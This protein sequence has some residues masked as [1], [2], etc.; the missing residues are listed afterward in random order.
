MSFAKGMSNREWLI[1]QRAKSLQYLLSSVLR[2]V[3]DMRSSVVENITRMAEEQSDGDLDIKKS[4]EDYY[5]NLFNTSIPDDMENT[6][7]QALIVQIDTYAESILMDIA[8]DK[9]QDKGICKIES[10]Y[11]HIQ[12]EKGVTFGP[13]VNH[14]SDWCRFHK[15]RNDITHE[16]YT[17]EKIS[18]QYIEDVITEVENLLVMVEKA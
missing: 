16:G 9:K 11:K 7:L 17:H 5:F 2:N 10:Y 6:F 14:W 18:K 4:I 8:L 13:L 3:E 1:H 15:M 12:V